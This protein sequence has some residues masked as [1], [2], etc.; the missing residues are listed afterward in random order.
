MYRLVCRPT[1]QSLLAY[2]DASERRSLW[3]RL[4]VRVRW[5]VDGKHVH[6]S[7]MTGQL[8]FQTAATGRLHTLIYLMTILF[9]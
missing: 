8:R 3:Y 9:L 7:S 5:V 6:I 1:H 2:S 4:I